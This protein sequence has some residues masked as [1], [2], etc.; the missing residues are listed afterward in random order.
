[1]L[2]F[3]SY[4]HSVMINFFEKIMIIA[5]TSATAY[6]IDEMFGNVVYV[7]AALYM[8]YVTLTAWGKLFNPLNWDKNC[9]Y[10]GGK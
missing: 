2:K 1:M 7:P 10:N 4:S 5:I 6:Y 3:D 8:L 9:W